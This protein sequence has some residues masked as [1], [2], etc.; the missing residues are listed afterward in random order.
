LIKFSDRFKLLELV[1][2]IRPNPNG[3]T[4]ALC[5][6]PVAGF[7]FRNVNHVSGICCTDEAKDPGNQPFRVTGSP[8]VVRPISDVFD[9]CDHTRTGERQ[10]SRGGRHEINH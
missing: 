8:R 3:I 4:Y 9:R 6:V 7:V 5:R 10:R 2:T 1:A